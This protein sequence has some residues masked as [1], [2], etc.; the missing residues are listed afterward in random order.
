MGSPRPL[1]VLGGMG[2]AATLDFLAKVQAR[3]P[4]GAR[5]QDH[6][7]LL[8]D[9]NPQVPDR[10]AALRGEGPSPAPALAAMAQALERAGAEGL[11]MVCNSAHAFAGDIRAA[12]SIPLISIIDETVERV[13]RDHPQ[14]RR[15]GL[16]AADACLRA[17]LY[18]DAFA[19]AGVEALSLKG[20]ARA[21]F[22]ALIYRIKGGDT[23]DGAGA[24]MSGL[25]DEL[26]ASGAE[27]IVSACTE[28]PLVLGP[29]DV[30][31]PLVDCTEVL[32]DAAI[33]FAREPGDGWHGAEPALNG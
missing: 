9:I 2:P 20:E 31:T 3:T 32:V 25:A 26:V 8:V 22:M 10:N 11:V 14:A 29:A 6:L 1:G 15:V 27:V 16:L 7:R 17:A 24:E 23:G 13:R 18:Q 30:R 28:V 4:P 12:V 19:A 5:D 33:R 21:R